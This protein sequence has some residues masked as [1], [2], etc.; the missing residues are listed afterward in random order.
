MDLNAMFDS[1]GGAGGGDP[2]GGDPNGAG[3]GEAIMMPGDNILMPGDEKEKMPTKTVTQSVTLNTLKDFI[4]HKQSFE[5][6]D[7]NTGG[8]D[9]KDKE[10]EKVEEKSEAE[11]EKD[12][13][14]KLEEEKN[15]PVNDPDCVP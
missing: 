11:K 13:Q 8:N 7:P 12:K 4:P 1:P 9:P 2:S 6:T 5:V 3:S 10:E 15:K 14:K